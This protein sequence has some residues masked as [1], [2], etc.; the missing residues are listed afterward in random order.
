MEEEGEAGLYLRVFVRPGPDGMKFGMMS[1]EKPGKNDEA[2]E[3]HGLKVLVDRLSLRTLEGATLD[4]VEGSG[5]TLLPPGQ[6]EKP[7][8]P[9]D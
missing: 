9:Q 1:E 7:S 2:S 6:T 5:F 8:H 4:Y 3:Q